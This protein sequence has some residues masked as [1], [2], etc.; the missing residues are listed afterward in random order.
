MKNILYNSLS[1]LDI[2]SWTAVILFFTLSSLFLWW[3]ILYSFWWAI[4]IIVL[5]FFVWFSIEL[6][7]EILKDKKWIWKISWF[8]TNWPEALV[9]LIWLI[10]WDILFASSTPL[11]SNIMNPLLLILAIILFWKIINFKKFWYKLFFTIWFLIL[12]LL[13]ISFF[14]IPENYYIYWAIIWL[15]FSIYFFSKKYDNQDIQQKEDEETWN[16]ISNIY[17][18]LAFIVLLISWYYL[19]PVLE[20]TSEVSAVSKWIIWFFVL[21][22]LTSWPEFKSIIS[23]L[24]RQK[25]LASFEN[26]LVSSITNIWLAIIWIVVWIIIWII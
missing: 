7:L 5:M 18:V 19:W 10:S 20:F 23:L 2:I 6:M 4:L 1:K 8:I 15:V 26:I 24:K 16:K 3:N 13:A 14:V 11:W 25:I 17:L 21:S 9:V 12:A 22:F